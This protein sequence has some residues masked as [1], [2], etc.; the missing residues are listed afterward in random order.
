MLLPENTAE[1]NSF[2]KKAAGAQ[3]MKRKRFRELGFK[4][5]KT[6]YAFF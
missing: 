6:N 3:L 1:I 2:L 5:G 4:I